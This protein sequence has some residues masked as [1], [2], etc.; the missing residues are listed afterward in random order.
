MKTKLFK[1]L[2]QELIALLKEFYHSQ[3]NITV[4]T[5][6]GISAESGIPTFR[7]EEGYWKVGSVNYQPQEIGT[8]RM[9]TQNPKE[10][11]KW[12][13]FRKTV[14]RKSEPNAGHLAVVEME[15]LFQDRFTLIT[16]NVDGLHL[17]AGNTL[18]KAFLIHG[19]LEYM[20]CSAECSTDLYP[21]P[22]IADKTRD[23]DIPEEEWHQLCCP[24]CGSLTRPHVLWFDE[25]YNE[26]FYKYQSSL[27]V[28]DKTDL[29]LVVGTSG[30]TN[31]PNSVVDIVRDNQ[32]TLIDI[33][34]T[35]NRFSWVAERYTHGHVLQAKSGE[36]LP[37]I[38]KVFQEEV[39]K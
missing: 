11:W 20:R 10:V 37:K 13:L 14:C 32:K 1:M 8:W 28:A 38:L 15:K 24:K 30:A 16:Q 35:E 22:K 25:Y 26:E 19:T 18:D 3:G 34:P 29:L 9:F 33:N 27:E 5:G 4:L 12:F 31:L 23:S 6:A 17:R 7:G 39:R 2:N 36:A 21:Y